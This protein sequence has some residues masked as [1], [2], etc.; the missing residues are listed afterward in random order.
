MGYLLLDSAVAE[1]CALGMLTNCPC[2]CASTVVGPNGFW[3]SCLSLALQ[4]ALV[5]QVL[6]GSLLPYGSH[7]SQWGPPVGSRLV[8]PRSERR[9]SVFPFPCWAVS[10]CCHCPWG[11]G[12]HMG[13][14]VGRFPLMRDQRFSLV[15]RTLSFWLGFKP[16]SEAPLCTL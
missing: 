5:F 8:C 10:S 9:F 1:P 3:P 2:G 6:I 12:H 11:F 14:C 4:L 7:L 16:L 13:Q 15:L